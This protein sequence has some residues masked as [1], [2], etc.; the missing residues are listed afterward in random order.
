MKKLSDAHTILLSSAS[1]RDGG[2]LVPLPTM[3]TNIAASSKAI[4][5]L[6]ANGIAEERKATGAEAFRYPQWHA[7]RNGG[8]GGG[9]M[10]RP[11][12]LLKKG[13]GRVIERKIA[14]A[15]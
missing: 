12:V 14:G 13:G 15:V 3:L 7:C 1:K 9:Q 11:T 10:P 6:V 8:A 2:N 4:A 5:A